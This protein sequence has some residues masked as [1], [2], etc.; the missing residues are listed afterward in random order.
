MDDMQ[1]L[2]RVDE[3]TKLE[4]LQ[5]IEHWDTP[6]YVLM[7]KKDAFLING[8]METY[9]TAESLT[10]RIQVIPEDQK[11]AYSRIPVIAAVDM[12]CQTPCMGMWL[13]GF[14]EGDVYISR[15]E[16]EPLKY[17]S[18]MII[19][20]QVAQATV[21]SER[22]VPGSLDDK[23]FYMLG[24]LPT[25]L[26]KEDDFYNFD[27]FQPEGSVV[28]YVKLYL[29]RERA[30]YYNVRNFDI[31]S[32]TFKQIA[33]YCRNM[34]YGIVIEPQQGFGTAFAPNHL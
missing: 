9:L 13:Y 7:P 16:L 18:E 6:L 25:A 19:K 23:V 1:R 22:K 30:E 12:V 3:P 34:K 26:T 33:K 4:R 27:T 32:Y 17:I 24:E 11:M 5:L 28:E 31:H 14:P 15:Q 21:L 20:L 2:D 10:K 8:V 29:T